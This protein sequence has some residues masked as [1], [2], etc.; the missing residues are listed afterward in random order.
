MRHEHVINECQREICVVVLRAI[1]FYYSI[2]SF[3]VTHFSLTVSLL[4]ET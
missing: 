3:V 2:N 1:S 4:Y